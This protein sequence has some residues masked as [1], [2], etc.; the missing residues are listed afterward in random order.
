MAFEII[1]KPSSQLT[2]TEQTR[3]AE[4]DHFAYHPQNMDGPAMPPGSETIVWARSEHHLLGVLDGSIVSIVCL[5]TREVRVG[6]QILAIAGVGNVATHPEFQR[7]GYAALLLRQAETCI[8]E[9]LQVPF[10]L[11][12]CSPELEPYYKKFGW[13][14]IADPMIFDTANGKQTWGE[15]TMVL[16]LCGSPWPS[17]LVDLCGLPW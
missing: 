14:T 4:V 8:R 11:L 3:A 12:V 17:G 10:A 6:S 2:S 7:R 13:E 16:S 1:I 5:F 9:Q 15:K